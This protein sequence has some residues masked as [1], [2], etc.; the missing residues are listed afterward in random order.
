[1][2]TL[3]EQAIAMHLIGDW[4]LQN[5]WM[6]ENKPNLKHPASWIH[7]GV[8]VVLQS[9]VLGLLAGVVLGILHMLIDTRIP[10]R[11]WRKTFKMTGEGPTATHVAIW[12]DQV[13]HLLCLAAWI[14]FFVPF[15]A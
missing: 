1:M 7:L 2:L 6:A 9:L 14:Q 4:V 11:W 5:H 10:F 13:L 3:F 8:H 12:T 15:P